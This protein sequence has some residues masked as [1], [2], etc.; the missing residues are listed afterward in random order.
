MLQFKGDSS[1]V[2]R[3][4]RPETHAKTG[5]TVTIT[6]VRLRLRC[7]IRGG[8]NP[9]ESELFGVLK[10]ILCVHNH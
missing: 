1:G 2:H 9:S 7:F 5:V 10:A 4:P 6:P 8:T 3:I